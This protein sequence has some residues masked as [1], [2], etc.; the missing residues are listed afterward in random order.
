MKYG[1]FYTLLYQI[2]PLKA[3]DSPDI[4]ILIVDISRY[5]I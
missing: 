4:L 1:V 5:K 2:I 3:T